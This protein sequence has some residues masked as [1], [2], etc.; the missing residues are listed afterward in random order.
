MGDFVEGRWEWK[1]SWRRDFFDHEI[2]MVADLL[3]EIDSAHLNQSNR[4]ILWWKPDPNGLFSTRTAYK[5]LQETHHSISQDNVLNTMWK[6]KIPPKV[7]AFSWR[8]LKNRLPSR[9]NLRKRQVTMP[10]Y[11]CP[12][13]D[14]EEESVDHLMFKCVMTRNLWW[15]PLS[16]VNRVGP[17]SIDPKNHFL[18]FTQ[19]SSKASTNRR[20]EFLWLALS[21]SIWHYRNAMIFKNQPFNPEKVMDDALFHTWSWLKYVEKDS[22]LHFHSWSTNLQDVFS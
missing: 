7:S 12:L 9:D 5:V 8:L 21:F 3:A 11:S 4:D 15:E 6:L 1:L 17:F 10:S 22:Q 20:W 2:Q 19:W 13:C 16:W 14:H 18:Q